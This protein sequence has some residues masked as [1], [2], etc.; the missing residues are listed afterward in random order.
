[1]DKNYFAIK[2]INNSKLYWSNKDGWVE[3]FFD[4]FTLEETETLNLPLEGKWV[5]F[6][7][8]I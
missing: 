3:K 6:H 4:M 1:M 5:K 8:D 7:N 2:C